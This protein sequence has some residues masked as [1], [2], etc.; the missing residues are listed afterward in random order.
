MGKLEKRRESIIKIMG[1][2][3]FALSKVEGELQDVGGELES[4][5]E[6][7]EELARLVDK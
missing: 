1:E 6:S 7:Y 2:N 4:I 3:K 5:R